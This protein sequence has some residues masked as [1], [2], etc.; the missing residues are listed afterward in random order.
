MQFGIESANDKT[1]KNIRKGINIK[2]ISEAINNALAVG[3]ENICCNYIIGLPGDTKES[4][5]NTFEY[6]RKFKGNRRVRQSIS[7]LTPYPGTY[8]YNHADEMG[9]KIISKDWKRYNGMDVVGET[10]NL[11]AKEIRKLYFDAYNE[12]YVPSYKEFF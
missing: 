4:L 1:L 2:Q 12:F 6:M 5:M 3:I 8:I 11:S 7:V 10:K 9:V